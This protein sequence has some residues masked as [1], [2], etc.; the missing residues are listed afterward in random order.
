MKNHPHTVQFVQHGTTG[1]V[2]VY[3]NSSLAISKGNWLRDG[4]APAGQF[5]LSRVKPVDIA[6]EKLAMDFAK[7]NGLSTE[8]TDRLFDFVP[9]LFSQGRAA[10]REEIERIASDPPS[11]SIDTTKGFEMAIDEVLALFR[12]KKESLED[13]KKRYDDP[14]YESDFDRFVKENPI[15]G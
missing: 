7:E 11:D 2:A 4:K 12:D 10:I 3:L 15:E 14:S 8:Q 13:W 5:I 1:E 6:W 9:I